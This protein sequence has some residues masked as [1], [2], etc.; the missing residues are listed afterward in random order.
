MPLFYD[1]LSTYQEEKDS[2]AF[3]EKIVPVSHEFG[4]A[5]IQITITEKG[6]FASAAKVDK[7]N[8]KILLAITE[9]S[10]SRTSGAAKTRPQGVN[11]KLMFIAKDM[12]KHC[13]SLADK[14]GENISYTAYKKQLEDWCRSEYSHPKARAILKYIEENDVIEDL[15]KSGVLKA[16]QNE[17]LGGTGNTDKD[18]KYQ[19][20]SMSVPIRFCVLTAESNRNTWEDVT[21]LE[22]W[23][24]YYTN[25]RD[26]KGHKELDGITGRVEDVPAFHPKKVLP[27]AANA[28]LIS[29][30]NSENTLMNFTGE[31]F[32]DESQRLQIGYD[33]SQKVHNT[34]R[35]LI[36]TQSIRITA[37]NFSSG[38][39]R[40]DCPRYMICWNPS[41]KTSEIYDAAMELFAGNRSDKDYVSGG[42]DLKKAVY[43]GETSSLMET[44]LTVAAFDAATTGRFTMVYY[45]KMMA[46]EFFERLGD[47][48]EKCSW[49]FGSRQN[50]SISSPSI[51]MLVRC[52]FGT[53]R[54]TNRQIYL[55]IDGKL[56]KKTVQDIVIRILNGQ[57]LPEY[58]VRALVTQASSPMR[59]DTY[60][61]SILRTACAAVR[62]M[63]FIH[64]RKG[65]AEMELNKNS[66]DRSYLFGRILAVEDAIEQTV[67]DRK[68][69][70]SDKNRATNARRLWNA[71]VSHPMTTWQELKSLLLPYESQLSA[72]SRVFYQKTLEEIV[73]KFKDT[74]MSC[75]ASS[76]RAL[77]PQYLLGFYLQRR[78]LKM[79]TKRDKTT[80]SEQENDASAS[81]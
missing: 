69:V 13:P 46:R 43:Y 25:L 48:Y 54:E 79:G 30:S 61:E 32:T 39:S 40:D 68:G 66:T 26:R 51:Y 15:I 76:N 24:S 11:D 77:E 19:K 67:L 42:N 74:D 58:V 57:P 1:L 37:G 64:N 73:S 14:S 35:W 9:E 20:T 5:E 33:T 23:A 41:F 27:G 75:L 12:A 71:Y 18:Q 80:G 70:S 45:Q 21:L 16:D 38:G 2:D 4:K 47:W 65:D 3:K 44:G 28:K 53:E 22:S 60:H 56:F 29:V 52:A 81:S 72:G 10:Q 6:E 62:Q 50:Q 8:E 17:V 36:G 34:L 49:Y 59:F 7:D 55:D 31:R 78:E 63:F